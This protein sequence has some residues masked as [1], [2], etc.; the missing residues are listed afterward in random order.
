MVGVNGAGKNGS[1]KTEDSPER[2]RKCGFGAKAKTENGYERG[3][4]GS[5]REENPM[6]S[7]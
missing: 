2:I 6:S 7:M 5:D 1:P 4:S 3:S